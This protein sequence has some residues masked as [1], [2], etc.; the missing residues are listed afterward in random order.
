MARTL[1]TS[2]FLA[3]MWIAIIAGTGCGT[4][5]ATEPEEE[6]SYRFGPDS[7]LLLWATE[8]GGIVK[9]LEVT[10]DMQLV[11][12]GL[13]AGW[14]YD[15]PARSIP[16]P[17]RETLTGDLKILRLD[18]GQI[19]RDIWSSRPGLNAGIVLTP[20]G[21]HVM[22]NAVGDTGMSG[23]DPR[24]EDF[25]RYIGTWRLSDGARLS[26]LPNDRL[27]PLALMPAGDAIVSYDDSLSLV[28]TLLNEDSTVWT[29]GPS[30]TGSS[31]P[32]MAMPDGSGIVFDAAGRIVM[33]SP[34]DGTRIWS[35]EPIPAQNW[36]TAMSISRDSRIIVLIQRD[37]VGVVRAS[38][39]RTIAR[40]GDPEEVKRLGGVVHVALTADVR[41]VVVGGGDGLVGIWDL[42]DGTPVTSFTAHDGAISR[43]SVAP[44]G[45]SIITG[46]ADGVVRAWRMPVLAGD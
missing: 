29:T 43:I 45:E 46:G 41:H 25:G 6:E 9:S 22:A 23:H 37:Y 33:L 26:V 32:L 21:L 15:R 31:S 38:D 19:V 20:D 44:D 4:Q 36:P 28:M 11:V 5:R 2:G 24:S 14:I 42:D 16:P 8:T 10:Q 39:G 13:E 1:R 12:A 17:M 34:A 40:L 27:W 3:G 18:D 7:T 30:Y 35:T